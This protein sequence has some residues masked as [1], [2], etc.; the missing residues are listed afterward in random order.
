MSKRNEIQAA[1]DAVGSNVSLA[2]RLEGWLGCLGWLASEIDKL[3]NAPADTET[4]PGT[5]PASTIS[6]LDMAAGRNQ[7]YQRVM[8]LI[9]SDPWNPEEPA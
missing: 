6:C 5:T 4:G 1:L 2:D 9:D 7:A 8:L 3:K